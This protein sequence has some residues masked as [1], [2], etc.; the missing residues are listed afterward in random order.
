[1]FLMLI[2]FVLCCIVHVAADTKVSQELSHNMWKCIRLEGTSSN[3]PDDPGTKQG[4]F[5]KDFN[6]SSWS[7]QYVPWNWDRKYPPNPY[8]VHGVNNINDKFFREGGVGWYRKKF[9]VDSSIPSSYRIILRFGMVDTEC[10]VYLNGDKIGEHQ[11]Y[12]TPFE[13]DVT[14]KISR[15]KENILA[16]RVYD[17]HYNPKEPGKLIPGIDGH[18]YGSSCGGIIEPV[19]IIG[20]PTVYI[21]NVKIEPRIKP[22]SIEVNVFITNTVKSNKKFKGILKVYPVKSKSDSVVASGTTEIPIS[23]NYGE[24][25]VKAKVNIS[26]PVLWKPSKPHLYKLEISL[27]AN[28]KSEEVYTEKFGLREIKIKDR[29][30][31]LNGKKLR[32]FGTEFVIPRNDFEREWADIA[33]NE[34]DFMR[35]ALLLFKKM[36][37]NIVRTHDVYPPVFYDI[38]DEIGLMVYGEYGWNNI[39]SPDPNYFIPRVSSQMTEWI[40]RDWNHPSIIFWCL[41]NE[42]KG[43]AV[44]LMTQMYEFVKKI[45]DTRPISSSSGGEFLNSA[46]KTDFVDVHSYEGGA[47][48]EPWT[49]VEEILH[50]AMTK[51]EESHSM[52]RPMM[53]TEYGWSEGDWLPWTSMQPRIVQKREGYTT[54]DMLVTRETYTEIAQKMASDGIRMGEVRHLGVLST[55]IPKYK[56][57]ARAIAWKRLE[58]RHRACD[59]LTG[60]V[61]FVTGRT[62]MTNEFPMYPLK[63]YPFTWRPV[64]DSLRITS[65]P[66]LIFLKDFKCGLFAGKKEKMNFYLANDS[67]LD[68]KPSTVKISFTDKDGKEYFTNTIT[69]PQVK[70]GTKVELP[71]IINVPDVKT[72]FYK[73]KIN[74]LSSTNKKISENYY[75][76]YVLGKSDNLKTLSGNAKLAVYDIAGKTKKILDSLNVKYDSINNFNKLSSFDTLIIGW[77][78]LDERIRDSSDKLKLFTE[79][80]GKIISFE[81]YKNYFRGWVPRFI[82]LGQEGEKQHYNV[83]ADVVDFTHPIFKGLVRENFDFWN[84]EHGLVAKTLLTPLRSS[85]LAG[86]GEM[87]EGLSSSMQ[88]VICEENVGKGKVLISQVEAT[89]AWQK[90]PSATKYMINM[91]NYGLTKEKTSDAAMTSGTTGQ[92]KNLKTIKISI[93]SDVSIGIEK[94]ID[95]ESVSETLNIS[96]KNDETLDNSL[97]SKPKAIYI[98]LK[99][100]LTKEEITELH[101]WIRNGGNLIVKANNN[102]LKNN[103]NSLMGSVGITISKEGYLSLPE[104]I[105]EPRVFKADI[106]K[107]SNHPINSGVKELN[108]KDEFGFWT[109]KT[110]KNANSLMTIFYQAKEY[111]FC[112]VSTEGKGRIIFFNVLV[113]RPRIFD[114]DGLNQSDKDNKKFISQLFEKIFN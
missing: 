57:Y 111:P 23:V 84:N 114:V 47:F 106:Q 109:V 15:D 68:I 4:F 94:F 86:A 18:M 49:F 10:T 107:F 113:E 78:S 37:F 48:G 89:S 34:G 7:D 75:D 29:D 21:R 70:N 1:M 105:M 30:L 20:R 61:N 44:P 62:I 80:G 59:F 24:N 91:I 45:D 41:G 60:Q 51:A 71:Y 27:V 64:C 33:L 66:V 88:I 99:R 40:Q 95:V 102:D 26:K 17:M 19:Y 101:Q 93:P 81:Q 14:D 6:D 32:L 31:L 77:S 43:N 5:K 79:A 76:F 100:S 96:E 16:V 11:G 65:Q 56:A 90:D 36:N 3:P 12:S 25:T 92:K 67:L 83:F 8:V 97:K 69:A 54:P 53:N 82:L 2:T 63:D 72:G 50:N 35:R 58:E 22:A 98:S 87:S 73:M 9:K 74:V 46:L 103:L 52:L 38:C 104:V 55:L 39:Y 108:L 85:I 13:F 28:G 112:V 42:N 110:S